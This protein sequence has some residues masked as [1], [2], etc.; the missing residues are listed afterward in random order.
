[1]CAFCISY[2]TRLA[3][4]IIGRILYMASIKKDKKTK[5]WYC[6]V[7]YQVDGKNKTKAK[8]GFR[9]KKEAELFASK[10]EDRLFKGQSIDEA[11]YGKKPKEQ[12]F[13]NYFEKWC[14]TYR[15]SGNISL[16]TYNKYIAE[17]K[18]VREFFGDEELTKIT[19]QEY[20][21]FLNK[22]GNGRSQDSVRKTHGRLNACFKRAQY[23]GLIVSNPAFDAKIN[24]TNVGSH[25][26]KYYTEAEAKT[27]FKLFKKEINIKNVFLYI[28]LST[29]LRLGEFMA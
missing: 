16:S 26:V 7:S 22:R 6:R 17:I 4:E 25:R 3:I 1:M 13:A 23:D 19:L 15:M 11:W 9:T 24:Y 18:R 20:Q 28:A 5:K 21:E 10:V 14:E 27:L 12:I 2:Y 29:G 8:K